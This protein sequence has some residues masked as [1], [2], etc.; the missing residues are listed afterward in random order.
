M[1]F[2]DNI[3]INTSIDNLNIKYNEKINI[4]KELKMTLDS[5]LYN[6]QKD[7]TYF[8]K[9]DDV[10]I[11]QEY[12]KV[13]AS[14]LS[15]IVSINEK[16]VVTMNTCKRIHNTYKELRTKAYNYKSISQNNSESN[17]SKI[18]DYSNI[19]ENLF[20]MHDIINNTKNKNKKNIIIYTIFNSTSTYEDLCLYYLSYICKSIDNS[21]TYEN[22]EERSKLMSDMITSMSLN[23]HKSI[24]ES[25]FKRIYNNIRK[26][27]P[28]LFDTIVDFE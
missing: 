23:C 12:L 13:I 14:T 28:T 19:I 16:L 3:I 6:S 1:E 8:I 26:I 27:S 18:T 4:F 11:N 24:M 15:E 2:V 25:A 20:A 9:N 5:V 17:E 21:A 7:N 10:K 22:Y